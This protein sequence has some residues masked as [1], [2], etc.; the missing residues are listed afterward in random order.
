MAANYRERVDDGWIR[1][2]CEHVRSWLYDIEVTEDDQP[3]G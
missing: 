1:R 2:V 3:A